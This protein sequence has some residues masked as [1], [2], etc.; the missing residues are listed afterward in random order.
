MLTSDVHIFVF[1][2]PRVVDNVL[3][4]CRELRDLPAAKT[5]VDVSDT[6]P[7]VVDDWEWISISP[8][9]H[10]GGQFAFALRI[11]SRPILF[12]IVG[13]MESTDWGGVVSACVQA[14]D[15]LPYLGVWAAEVDN[16]AWQTERV[17]IQRIGDTNLYTTA[18]SD[19]CVWAI[20]QSIAER[21]K[22][23][24]FK[25]N[26]IGWGIDW[27]AIAASYASG[28]IVVRDKSVTIHH[29]PGTGYQP[30][31]AHTQM[32]TFLSQLSL[33]EKALLNVL[34]RSIGAAP[35]PSWEGRVLIDI[36]QK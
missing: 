16:T 19:C 1:C 4:I 11:L 35:T 26:N 33:P 36:G 27:A 20:H 25:S 7:R 28:R 12:N 10:F 13:D 30:K 31:A 24:D 9:A 34:Y 23:L 14:F 29:P 5:V 8:A 17:A 6:P 22:A 15:Q 32:T 18:Q 2:W 21:L 3:H